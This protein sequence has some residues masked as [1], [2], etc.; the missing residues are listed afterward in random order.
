[1][2]TLTEAQGPYASSDFA[3]QAIAEDEW[4][5]RSLKEEES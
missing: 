5:T 1:M 2:A 3:A 4:I